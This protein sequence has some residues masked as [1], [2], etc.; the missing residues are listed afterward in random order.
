VVAPTQVAVDSNNKAVLTLNT[1]Q[2]SLP[3]NH[4]IRRYG[5]P[6]NDKVCSNWPLPGGTKDYH[7]VLWTVEDG[8]GNVSSCSYLLRLEDCKKPTPI[9]VGL[10]SVVMPNSGCVTIWA[11]DFD[12]GSSVD[13]C[14]AHDDLLFSFSGQTYQP[15]RQFCCEDLEENGSPSFL[16]EIWVGDEGNDQNCNGF[17]QPIGIEWSERNK[18]YCTTFI[19]IDDN[20]EVCPGGIGV[21]GQVE[22]EDIQN[23]E[24]VMVEMMDQSGGVVSSYLTNQSGSYHFSNPLV[25]FIL[26][27]SRNDN[28]KNGVSTLDLVDIQKHLLGLK[29]LDSPYKLIAADANNSKSVSVVDLVEIRKLILGHY[30]EFPNNTSWRFVDAEFDFNDPMHPWPF[31]ETIRLQSGM[32]MNED[33]VA[34]KVGDVNST[35]R[36]NLT[37]VQT[38]GARQVLNLMIDD[39]DVTAGEDVTIAVN[40]ANFTE[41]LGYQFTLATNSLS[42][43]GVE[44]G[45]I[46]MRPDYIAVHDEAIT[47]SWGSA[48]PVSVNSTEVLFTLTFR[49]L[50]D[51]K[52][53]EMLKIGSQITEAEAYT[54]QGDVVEILDV[55]LNFGSV[56]TEHSLE[57]ALYQNEPNPFASQTLIGFD[58]PEA[59]YAT[60]TVFDL[61]GRVIHRIEGDFVQGFNQVTLKAKEL[62]VAGA[63]YYRLNAGDFTATKKL[64]LWD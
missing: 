48:H 40:A 52:L 35:V 61:H 25:D 46:D 3:S 22:T 20:E 31:N 51:G 8:C 6:Y 43:Q 32:T 14:T 24:K 10:S 42:Y 9:C 27:P 13:D 11:K 44:P 26:K 19:V 38:R 58:L 7:R 39:R 30:L 36:A 4:P 47:T 15:S 28:H 63:Y 12:A 29:L 59:L 64:I 57:Y 60:L 33:F 53:S 50:K 55:A 16:V 1:K 18:D 41:V 62:S 49:A 37:Q 5:L 23:V 45:A 2:N 17:V 56:A 54:E 21:G 34:I